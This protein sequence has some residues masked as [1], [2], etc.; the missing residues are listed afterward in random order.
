[1]RFE[2]D[3]GAQQAGFYAGYALS[4]LIFTTILYLILRFTGKTDN[5]CIAPAI[6][7][8]VTAI[9]YLLRRWLA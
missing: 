4:F 1:M 9:A 7:V 2:K 8:T 3:E 5:P 6:T